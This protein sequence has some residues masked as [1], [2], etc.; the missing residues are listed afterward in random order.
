MWNITFIKQISAHT[1][2][3]KDD[4]IEVRRMSPIGKYFPFKNGFETAIETTEQISSYAYFT[5]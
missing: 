5:F 3:R 1:Y 4:T 2:T